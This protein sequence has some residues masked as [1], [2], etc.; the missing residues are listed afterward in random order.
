M[1]IIQKPSPNF[2]SRVQVLMIHGTGVSLEESFDYL[3]NGGVSCHYLIDDDGTIYQLVD[4]EKRAWHGGVG[5]WRGLTDINS[6]SIGIELVKPTDEEVM[7]PG[8]KYAE[9][10]FHKAYYSEQQMA[11]LLEL[12]K[13][14]LKRHERVKPCCVIGHQDASVSRKF[15]PGQNFDWR[16]LAEN[17]VGLWHDLNDADQTDAS[18]LSVQDQEKCL[19]MLYAYGYDLRMRSDEQ[20]K[21]VVTAF[22]THF[23]PKQISGKLNSATFKAIQSLTAKIT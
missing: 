13:D 6:A 1:H 17:G 8:A 3:I 2:N 10:L 16:Y 5:Y 11:S 7:L 9:K 21:H 22:Q 19:D 18:P 4:D 12:S 20:I 15:D 14:I 23:L